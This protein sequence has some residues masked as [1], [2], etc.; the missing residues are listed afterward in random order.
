MKV[1][2]NGVDV[3]DIHRN[4]TSDEWEKLKLVGGQHTYIY[5][6]CDY[7]NNRGSGRFDGCGSNGRGGGR[8]YN[9]CGSYTSRGGGRRPANNNRS[10]EPSRAI[11]AAV[12]THNS[13]E[14]VEHDADAV[15]NVSSRISTNSSDRGGR[16]GGRFGPRWDQS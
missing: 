14:I 15:S 10:S 16:V 8:S 3:S 9:D 6:R 5:Q 4:F 12:S 13:T 11:A 7:L 1:M 2:M